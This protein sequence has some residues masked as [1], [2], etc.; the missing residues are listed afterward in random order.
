M[1]GFLFIFWMK[2]QLKSNL[3]SFIRNS[4]V[5][6]LNF[7]QQDVLKKLYFQIFSIAPKIQDIVSKFLES[8]W[9][10]DFAISCWHF[11]IIEC[12]SYEINLVLNHFKKDGNKIITKIFFPN[13][14]KFSW[15][16]KIANFVYFLLEEYENDCWRFF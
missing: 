13:V 16:K 3:S 4:C 2:L 9:I 15:R 10:L 5:F 11:I 1:T 6:Y 7:W 14:L 8:Y 12:S